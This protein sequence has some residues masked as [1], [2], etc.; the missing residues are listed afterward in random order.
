MSQ[1]R[2]VARHLG[3]A[4]MPAR[5]TTARSEPWQALL[6]AYSHNEHYYL[7]RL[8]GFL[9]ERGVEPETVT[10]ADFAAYRDGLHMA[11]VR[12]PDLT[13]RD[14]YANWRRVCSRNPTL[15][16]PLAAAPKIRSGYWREWSE[17]L[18]TLEAEIDALYEGRMRRSELNLATLFDPVAAN[19]TTRLGAGGLARTVPS[20]GRV[21]S[22]HPLKPV[23]LVGERGGAG[24]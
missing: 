1:Y 8:S 17:F 18:A 7:S 19:R 4:E 14:T 11:A 15:P 13:Y 9:T 21:L 3:L 24:R 16:L 23:G 2:K 20:P 10:D 22:I 12:E 5:I 6:A